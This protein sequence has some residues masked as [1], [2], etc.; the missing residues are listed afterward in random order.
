ME[1]ICEAFNTISTKCF[2]ISGAFRMSKCQISIT[3][4]RG[5]RIYYGGE[6]VSGKV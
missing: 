4:D 6:T 5:D 2:R 1:M 3:F